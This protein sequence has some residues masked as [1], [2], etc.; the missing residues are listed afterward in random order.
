MTFGFA[1]MAPSSGIQPILARSS[2]PR[3]SRCGGN[4]PCISSVNTFS[5]GVR[6]LRVKAE[7]HAIIAE[8]CS[9]SARQKGLVKRYIKN[10]VREEAA[11]F[12]ATGRYTRKEIAQKCGIS[13]RTLYLWEKKDKFVARVQAINEEFRERVTR[14]GLALK[15]NRIGE[16]TSLYNRLEMLLELRA[17]RPEFE[18]LPGHATGLLAINEISPLK[19]DQLANASGAGEPTNPV[20]SASGDSQQVPALTMLSGQSKIKYS[21]DHAT[22]RAMCEIL[23]QIAI[24]TGDRVQRAEFTLPARLDQFSDAQIVALAKR[25]DVPTE[26]LH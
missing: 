16:L 17:A 7:M 6:V 22:V 8:T 21:V 10:Q 20:A 1:D 24:E 12:L 5:R 2:L 4:E 11:Q 19:S 25:L 3:R 15:D 18:F 26:L 23:T 14:R 9:A 13:E